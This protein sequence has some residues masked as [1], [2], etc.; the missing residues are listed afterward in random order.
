MNMLTLQE[1]QIKINENFGTKTASPCGE[2]GID[3]VI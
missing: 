2:A 3:T 1:N